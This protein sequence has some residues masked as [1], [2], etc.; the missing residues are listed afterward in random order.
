MLGFRNAGRIPLPEIKAGGQGLLILWGS[1]SRQGFR[2]WQDNLNAEHSKCW[3]H[4]ATRDKGR[5][6]GLVDCMG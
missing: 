3:T 1:G 5:R 4:S 2:A 6:A